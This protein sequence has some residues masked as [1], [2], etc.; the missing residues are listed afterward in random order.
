MQLAR[1]GACSLRAKRFGVLTI[2]IVCGNAIYLD[3]A[4]GLQDGREVD[5]LIDAPSL[6]RKPLMVLVLGQH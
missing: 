3:E 2:G 5:V 6:N 4:L 1:T